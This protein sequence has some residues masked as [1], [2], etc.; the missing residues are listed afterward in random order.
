MSFSSLQNT[1]LSGYIRDFV[2][3]LWRTTVQKTLPSLPRPVSPFPLR[4]SEIKF[5]PRCLQRGKKKGDLWESTHETHWLEVSHHQGHRRGFTGGPPPAW[6]SSAPI[7]ALSTLN[8]N[9]SRKWAAGLSRWA[10]W[11]PSLSDGQL[12]G[13]HKRSC[14]IFAA[15]LRTSIQGA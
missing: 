3:A 7:P 4:F 11:D 6:A 14:F 9:Q 5:Q 2:S 8:W 15:V 1:P 12:Q 10:M 13:A